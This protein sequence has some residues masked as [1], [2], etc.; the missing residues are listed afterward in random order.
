MRQAI[1]ESLIET[2]LRKKVPLNEINMV[3]LLSD[4]YGKENSRIFYWKLDGKSTDLGMSVS[5]KKKQGLYLSEN[6]DDIEMAGKKQNMAPVR[7]KWMKLVDLDEPTSF[8]D[9]ENVGCTQR[10][11]KPNEIVIKEYRKNLRITNSCWSN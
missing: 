3:I 7:K 8:L 5:S 10:E 1:R 11:C 9:Q 2:R 6:L 4:C